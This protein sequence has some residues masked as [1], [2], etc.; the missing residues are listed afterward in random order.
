MVINVKKENQKQRILFILKILQDISNEENPISMPNLVQSCLNAGIEA[1]RRSVYRDI[2]TL[3][4]FGYDI[5]FTK[6]PIQGYYLASSTFEIAELKLLVDA[7]QSA[8]FLTKKKSKELIE[9]ISSLTNI[10]QGDELAGQLLTYNKQDNEQIYYNIDAIQ[11]AISHQKSITFKYFDMMINNQKKYRKQEKKYA[12]VPYAL[13]WNKE[14]Y[15]C[16]GYDVKHQNFSHYRLDK[17]DN[18]ES[19]FFDGE[20]I[21]LDLNDYLVKI[22][23]M[24]TGTQENVTLRFDNSLASQVF[25]QFGKN[26]IITHKDDD[27]FTINLNIELAPPF[28]NWIMQYTNRV[29]ILSPQSLIDTIK[30]KATEILQLY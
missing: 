26:M 28:I 27:T 29:K 7:I 4:D 21:E 19:I 1:E 12:L 14:R 6:T 9:K 30:E 22:M 2:C 24:Y 5:I 15:Y 8:Q 17:M 11:N 25:D 3:V 23:G 13:V 18:I 10:Y 20:K 16:I